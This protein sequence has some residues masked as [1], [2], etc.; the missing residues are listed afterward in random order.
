MTANKYPRMYFGW[1]F[2]FMKIAS[3]QLSLVINHVDFN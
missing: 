3:I 2:F 1:D